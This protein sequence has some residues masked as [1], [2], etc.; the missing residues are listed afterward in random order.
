MLA[1]LDDDDITPIDGAV[2]P[3]RGKARRGSVVVALDAVSG[4]FVGSDKPTP[5][6]PDLVVRRPKWA[7]MY[8][9]LKGE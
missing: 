9:V 7:A 5:D 4:E 8:R 1:A 3:P 6:P 2:R